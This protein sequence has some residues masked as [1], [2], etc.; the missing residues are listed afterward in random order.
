MIERQRDD[1]KLAQLAPLQR[2]KRPTEIQDAGVFI[3]IGQALRIIGAVHRNH[4]ALPPAQ[5]Q[6]PLRVIGVVMGL[7]DAA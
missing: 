4:Q 2:T 3:Q 5:M 7:Q 6:K 1:R